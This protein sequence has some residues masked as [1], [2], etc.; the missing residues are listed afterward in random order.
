MEPTK[1]A[2][3][4]PDHSHRT[5]EAAAWVL[6]DLSVETEESTTQLAWSLLP[7]AEGVD[8]NRRRFLNLMK[9]CITNLLYENDPKWRK[10][11][12]E[13]WDWPLH[14]FSMIG[15]R[16]LNNIEQ[17]V[18][19]V[20]ADNVPGDFIETGTWR[21]GASIFA[22]AVFAA[23]DVRDRMVWV[24]DSFEGM[25]VPDPAKY[26]AD[27]GVDL[28][29][30]RRLRVSLEETQRNFR[31]FG[32]LDDQVRFL[33][34]WFKDTLPDAPIERLS[35][36]RLD[37]DLYESTIDALT[38]LYPRLSTGGFVIVDDFWFPACQKAVDDYRAAHGI[39]DQ[40][41]TIDDQGAYWRR[42]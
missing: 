35:I 12:V 4:I 30:E 33:K 29:R 36:L 16:R 15:L 3:E 1:P 14:A 39:S 17:C 8:A 5:E 7:P 38:H 31:R 27:T 42:S 21:G 23:H 2:A 6:P 11:C 25:P 41:I 19:Q 13:G 40:I 32:L 34:G 37:G 24:A 22:R 18:E 9:L 20:L 26:P 10:M 28:S